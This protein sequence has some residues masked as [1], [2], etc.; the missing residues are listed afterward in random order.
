MC[1]HPNSTPIP[2]FKFFRIGQNNGGVMMQQMEIVSSIVVESNVGE[3]GTRIP[4]GNQ[5]TRRTP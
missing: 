1:F 4:R 3:E 5:Y 2:S